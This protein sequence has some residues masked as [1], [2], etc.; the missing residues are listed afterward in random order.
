MSIVVKPKAPSGA[1]ELVPNDTYNA[2]LTE[3]WQFEN[4][5]G[6]R[7]GFEFTLGGKG[8]EGEKV[9][10]SCSPNLSPKSKLAEVLRS[11][12]GRDLTRDE[13]QGID[14][15]ELVGTECRVLVLQSQG[16]SGQLFSNV[17]QVFR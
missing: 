10:L 14:I 3:V 9:M 16:K 8:V 2:K 17:E 6:Q 7:L 12:L 5:Y 13:C 4:T 1:A 15:E 11:L